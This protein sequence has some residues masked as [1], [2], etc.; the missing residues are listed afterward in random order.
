MKQKTHKG[1]AKRIKVNGKGKLRREQ[2]GKRHLNEKL[3]SKRRRKLSGTTDVAK[4]DV[5]RM[6]RL[7]GMS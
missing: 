4:N 2:A 7:L 1:T 3:S 6:K 5:K